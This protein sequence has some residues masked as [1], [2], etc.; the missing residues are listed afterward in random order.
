M[1]L[2]GAALP[3]SASCAHA[4]RRSS[5][6]RLDELDGRKW[7]PRGRTRTRAPARHSGLGPLAGRDLGASVRR[8]IDAERDQHAARILMLE[9]MGPKKPR[10]ARPRHAEDQ[11][12]LRGQPAAPVTPQEPFLLGRRLDQFLGALFFLLR[13]VRDTRRQRR[14]RNDPPWHKTQRQGGDQHPRCMSSVDPV[15]HG[16][17]TNKVV[18]SAIPMQPD[19]SKEKANQS[20]D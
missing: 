2:L 16:A 17:L 18:I 1:T 9:H 13:W 19:E 3:S 10:R 4:G 8:R 6:T 20:I 11:P 14:A 15:S 7:N 12:G 5:D